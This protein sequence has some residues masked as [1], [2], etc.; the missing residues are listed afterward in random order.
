MD[1]SDL[2]TELADGPKFPFVN[3]VPNVYPLAF[4]PQ[5]IVIDETTLVS[6]GFIDDAL[7]A[8]DIFGQMSWVEGA[9]LPRD[10]KLDSSS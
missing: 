7:V 1:T 2:S 9:M 5:C 3:P 8:G 4:K 6:V 10:A